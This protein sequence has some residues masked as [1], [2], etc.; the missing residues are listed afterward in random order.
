MRRIQCGPVAGLLVVL[1]LSACSSSS[2]VAPI[3]GGASGA[4]SCASKLPREAKD[5]QLVVNIPSDTD[6]VAPNITPTS[7][8]SYTV[9]LP[10]RCPGQT[11]P[12]VL[13]SHGYSGTR[14]KAIGPNADLQPELAHFPSINRLVDALPYYGYVVISYDERGHGDSKP[15]NGGAYARIIDPEAEVRDAIAILDWAWDNSITGG[16]GAAALP[17]QTEATGIA[18]DLRVG[19]I[20]Y[21]YGGGFEMPL[22]ALDAR[23]DTIVPNGTWHSLIYSLLPGDGVK[24]GFDGLLCLLANNGGVQNTPLVATLCEILGPFNPNANNIRTRGNLAAAGASFNSSTATRRFGPAT[25]TFT[26]QET[27]D[28]FGGK[29]TAYFKNLEQT[30]KPYPGRTTPFKLRS[31][32]ALFVQ[33]NRDSLFNMTDGYWNWKY[34]H[35]A[36]ANKA[37][38]RFI[39]TDGGH[40]NPLANQ[41]E[42]P[43]NCGSITGVSAMLAWFDKQLKGIDSAVYNAIPPVCIAVSATPASS[44]IPTAVMGLELLTVPVGS[45]SG[46]GA[47]PALLATATVA[48]NPTHVDPNPL[49]VKMADIVGDGFVL[50]GI[51]TLDSIVVSAGT[52][53]ALITPVAYVGVG[54]RRGTGPAILVDQ[55]VTA[56]VEGSHTNNRN[57]NES[58]NTKVLLPGVGEVL[59]DGD[60][61]G[62]LFYCTQVQ[63]ESVA[64]STNGVGV[65][66]LLGSVSGENPPV[67]GVTLANTGACANNY[68]ATVSNAALPILKAGSYPGSA[69]STR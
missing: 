54:I 35:D 55:V 5:F 15:A 24:N 58:D 7:K 18:K 50:A 1:A 57:L 46:T 17:V 68:S 8:I 9:M 21:S 43:A 10:E 38:V 23:I 48:V 25:R 4:V 34:F 40:M 3:G 11:F 28:F 12:V 51:P 19:T 56:F 13:Q 59:R 41:V 42:A 30:G 37:D 33:G 67:T 60:Q 52:P 66:G 53:G 2:G 63:H 16:K 45:L 69:L 29:S 65:L 47:L 62:L 61:V 26:E 49:F 64:S 27:L 22:A 39:T 31:V 6:P 20:G 36:A 14:E 44:A 32:P